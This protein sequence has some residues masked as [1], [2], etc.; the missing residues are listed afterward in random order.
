MGHTSQFG[1]PQTA[2]CDRVTDGNIGTLERGG[3]ILNAFERAS[4]L[5]AFMNFKEY[6]QSNGNVYGDICFDE[7]HKVGDELRGVILPDGSIH[8]GWGIWPA[9]NQGVAATVGW[10]GF[11]MRGY[12]TYCEATTI[13]TRWHYGPANAIHCQWFGQVSNNGALGNGE[14]MTCRLGDPNFTRGLGAD[15]WLIESDYCT[16]SFVDERTCFKP[17]P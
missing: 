6:R 9:S 4:E 16:G 10:K 12:L 11:R 13:E 7:T 1:G 3:R 8:F 15:V 5:V 17:V 14:Q 2:F